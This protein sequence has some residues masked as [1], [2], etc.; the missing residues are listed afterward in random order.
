[1]PGRPRT[2]T[3]VKVI[4][5][6]FRKD[7]V[8]AA[9]P[10]PAAAIPLC[11]PHLDDEAKKEW[12]RIA[13]ELVTLG[14]LTKIDRAALAAYCQ[15]WSRWVEAEIKLKAMGMVVKSP[16]GYPMLSPYLPIA[17]KAL[18]QM[19]KF[20]SEF[21]IGPASRSR[22]SSTAALPTA[23]TALSRYL[24]DEKERRFFGA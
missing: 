6:T 9:E 1:M 8:N 19:Q 16:N 15:C 23:P 7:R 4:R 24:E 13:K 5:G 2:P 10:Q 11:P 14:L 3:A 22:I 20:A 17:T 21:G 18:E 12:R